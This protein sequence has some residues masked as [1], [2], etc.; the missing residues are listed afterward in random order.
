MSNLREQLEFIKNIRAYYEKHG[1]IPKNIQK[2]LISLSE[3]VIT[4]LL[5]RGA[6]DYNEIV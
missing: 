5:D 1:E 4:D 3:S 6:F 2:K